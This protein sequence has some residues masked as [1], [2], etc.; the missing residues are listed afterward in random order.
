MPAAYSHMP[1]LDRVD[2][3]ELDEVLPKESP[4]NLEARRRLVG[5]YGRNAVSLVKVARPGELQPI[6]GTRVLW[7]EL[8]WAARAEGVVHLDDLLLRRVRLGLLLSHGGA[9]L[10]P[11]IRA[12]CQPELGWDDPR[13]ESE[14]AGYL[15]LWYRSYSLPPLASVPDWKAMLVKVKAQRDASKPLRREKM[16][17]RTMIAMALISLAGVFLIWLWKRKRGGV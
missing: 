16:V 2:V 11:A 17:K 15:D 6:P 1:V 13:W 7:A 12:I 5:R 9:E 4:L 14:A 3:R 10:M 8:R